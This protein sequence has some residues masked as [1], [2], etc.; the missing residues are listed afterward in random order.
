MEKPCVYTIAV[1][2]LLFSVIQPIILR[3]DRG[4]TGWPNSI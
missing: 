3:V 1:L 2:I 4:Y